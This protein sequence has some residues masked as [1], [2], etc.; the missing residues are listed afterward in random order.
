M[1]TT[2]SFEFYIKL[3]K[4]YDSNTKKYFFLNDK[5]SHPSHANRIKRRDVKLRTVER[6]PD[7]VVLPHEEWAG[8]IEQL[9]AH[10]IGHSFKR[11]ASEEKLYHLQL[12]PFHSSSGPQI[13]S[14]ELLNRTETLTKALSLLKKATKREEGDHG[15]HFSL[16]IQVQTGKVSAFGW[17]DPVLENCLF[18]MMQLHFRLAEAHFLSDQWEMDADLYLIF[19]LSCVE[20][21]S[22][23]MKRAD[24]RYFVGFG[25]L[26]EMNE[27]W[28]LDL[29]QFFLFSDA[30]FLLSLSAW[31]SWK[32]TEMLHLKWWKKSC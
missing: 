31:W 14:V 22:V 8:P 7:W 27:L 24:A 29:I 15:V 4:I 10:L 2:F 25:F 26:S 6:G 20:F 23:G 18:R 13:E 3:L 21:P 9:R 1:R 12:T 28:F 19:V 30:F 32:S 11:W 5:R 16:H 17:S